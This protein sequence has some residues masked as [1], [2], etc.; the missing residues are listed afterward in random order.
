MKALVVALVM[1]ATATSALAQEQIRVDGTV[2]WLSGQTLTLQ[3]DVPGPTSYVI[4]GQVLVPVQRPRPS[5]DVDLSQLPQS[6]YAFMRPGERVAVI[7]T[8]ASEGHRV[9]ATSILRGSGAET[10]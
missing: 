9:I 3:T 7:G 8:L 4:V 10:P 1:I 6:E 2:R 5:V